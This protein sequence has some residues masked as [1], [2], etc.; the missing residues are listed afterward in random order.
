MQKSLLARQEQQAASAD[1]ASSGTVPA[2][3]VPM[4]QVLA[5]LVPMPQVPEVSIQL[6]PNPF[7]DVLKRS[8]QAEPQVRSGPLDLRQTRQQP[9]EVPSF[10]EL[11]VHALF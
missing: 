8:G 9:H 1:A 7:D 3:S 2:Q 5:Q 10:H 6:W 4:L 11:H